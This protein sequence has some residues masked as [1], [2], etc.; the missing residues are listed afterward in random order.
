MYFLVELQQI[1]FSVSLLLFQSFSTRRSLFVKCLACVSSLILSSVL[2]FQ[3]STALQLS[4]LSS[5]VRSL[6]KISWE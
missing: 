4:F 2:A 1:L 6:R 3:V 5:V